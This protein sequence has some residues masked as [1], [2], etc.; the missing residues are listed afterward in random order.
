MIRLR[1]I[2]DHK[3]EPIKTPKYD[4]NKIKGYSLIP[5]LYCTIFL[6]AQ[7]ESGKTNAILKS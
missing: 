1:K 7:K 5:K 2:N 6:C 3:I 4:P